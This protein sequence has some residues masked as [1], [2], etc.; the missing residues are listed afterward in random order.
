MFVDLVVEHFD[1]EHFCDLVLHLV[2]GDAFVEYTTAIVYFSYY[3]QVDELVQVVVDSEPV[4]VRLF[5]QFFLVDPG[6]LLY[7]HQY[8]FLNGGELVRVIVVLY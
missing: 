1:D 8:A 4:Q 6:V 3:A 7:D 5:D 2:V